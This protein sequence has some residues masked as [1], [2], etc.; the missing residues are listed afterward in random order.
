MPFDWT[1]ALDA[2]AHL[3]QQSRDPKTKGK[4]WIWAARGRKSSRFANREGRSHAT[5]IETPDS[6]KTEGDLYARFARDNPILFL[7]RQE[8]Q[9][10]N[11]KTGGKEWRGTP[12]YWPVIRVQ[13]NAQTAVY[14]TEV[15]EDAVV[16]I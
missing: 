8:G 1:S 14:A 7:L 12:F 9:E 5:F 2:L 11:E 6:T 4:I 13:L 16:A 3:S 15:L 10:I